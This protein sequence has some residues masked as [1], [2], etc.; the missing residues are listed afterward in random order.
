MH[1]L[2]RSFG[3]G[4]RVVTPV[5][6]TSAPFGS[7]A[8]VQDVVA[9][10]ASAHPSAVALRHGG[11]TLSYADL[12]SRANALARQL[13]RLGVGPDMVVGVRLE[14]SLDLIVAVLGVLRAGAAYTPL[15]PAYPADRLAYMLADS[16]ARALITSSG[17]APTGDVPALCL[18]TLT[19]EPWAPPPPS[20]VTLDHL[21]YVIYTSGSTGRPKGVAMP[22]R[23]LSNLLAWQVASSPLGA[24]HATLQFTSVS[25]DVS[26]QEIFA[27]LAVGG[28]LVL[29]DEMTRR[30]PRAMLA[31]M[32]EQSIARLFLPFVALQQLALVGAD[33]A[34]VPS[35]VE[36]VTAGEQLKTT[37]A[38]VQ[39]LARH[40]ACRLHNHYGPAETHVVTAHT[41]QGPPSTWP[42]LPPIGTPLPG[43]EVAL[44]DADRQPVAAGAAGEIYLGGVCLSRGYLNR[45]ELTGERFEVVTIAGKARRMYRTGDRG[46]LQTDGAYEFLGRADDQVKIRGFRVEPGEVET[47]LLQHP[48]VR[49]AAVVP[50]ADPSGALRLVAYVVPSAAAAAASSDAATQVAQWKAVWDDTYSQAAPWADVTLAAQGWRDSSS[51]DAYDE[52]AMREWAEATAARARALQPRAVYEIG[53]GTGMIT[54][55][56][57][58]HCH[59]YWANDMSAAAVAH[60]REHAAGHGAGHVRF[61]VRDAVDFTGVP[62]AT[63]DLVVMNSVAQHLP[64]LDQLTAVLTGAARIV[65]PGGFVLVGDMPSLALLETFHADAVLTAAP[66]ATPVEEL[67]QR[68]QRQLQLERELVVAPEYF[69]ALPALVPG[70]VAADVRLRHGRHDTEMNRCRYDVLLRIGPAPAALP[71][72][73]ELDWRSGTLSTEG[74]A[75]WLA[76]GPP[77]VRVVRNVPNA[78]LESSRTLAERLRRATDREFAR[79]VREG[80]R[81]LRR[82]AVHPDAWREAAA[83]AGYSLECAFSGQATEFDA[84]FVPAGVAGPLPT[85]S[86]AS[87]AA[88]AALSTNPLRDA[89]SRRLTPELRRHLQERLPDY[90]VPAAMVVMDAL[91][92]TPSGKTDRRALPAPEARRPD[93]DVA[94]APPASAL[95]RDLAAIWQDVLQV[96]RVGLHDNFFDLGGHSLLAAQVLERVRTLVPSAVISIVDLFQHSTLHALAGFL[97]QAH[98]QR[99]P[100]LALAQDRGRRQRATLTRPGRRPGM[101][102]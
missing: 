51:G 33:D 69:A 77:G 97:R 68:V 3:L 86:L 40:P 102:A 64:S 12:D 82:S 81:L 73:E 42:A 96:S 8:L 14:R 1:Q 101:S 59:S 57:A 95:E 37:P 48:S 98:E 26:F 25:F 50:H 19:S 83:G 76:S 84:Y 71:L 70:V 87:R 41:L 13:H 80:A 100:T 88:G 92:T 65:T 46:R 34:P 24:G 17:S 58:P 79:D 78:R 45:P 32:R 63:F 2:S 10:V 22:H 99:L 16:G 89:V 90:M 94:F 43:V 47:L 27:T 62:D 35:L 20:G 7:L 74:I 6:P 53:C 38:L 52:A 61:A 93:L 54:F 4:A 29:I 44:L 23:A 28:A 36:I 91:P 75:A 9:R 5:Q 72:A 60:V 15:D 67:R 66:D 49:E 31:L 85:A 18:D 39:W 11:S 55:R 21:A 56:L 30:D